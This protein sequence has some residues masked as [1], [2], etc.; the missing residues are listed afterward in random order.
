MILLPQIDTYKP[1]TVN[2]A[3]LNVNIFNTEKLPDYISKAKKAPHAEEVRI[4]VLYLL[5]Q[6]TGSSEYTNAIAT[7]I[8]EHL[9]EKSDIPVVAVTFDLRNHGSR[10][11]DAHKNN[12]WAKGN[13]SH[14]LDMVSSLHGNVADL[15]TI[16][17]FVPSYLDLEPLVANDD[18]P[19]KYVNAVSGYSLGAH[20]TI[21]FAAKH[22]ELVSV[23][24]TNVGCS[25]VTSL[26]VNRLR[27]T[28][29]F[30]KKWF[31]YEYNELQLSEQQ[32]KRLPEALFKLLAAED[33]YI[34]EN[35]PFSQINLFASFYSDDPLVPAK[36]STSWVDIYRNVNPNSD[37]YFEDGRVHNITPAMLE[38]FSSY[39]ANLLH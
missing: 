4:H 12:T 28:A 3:G 35:F 5:H 7:H 38:K 9:S 17:D 30:D 31:F 33:Q 6:R 16:M 2:I 23:I 22:P 37:V 34:F 29:E 8:L 15:K 1:Q 19:I 14:A 18:L 32:K 10:T 11:V 13:E 25:D 36:I 26:L 21:R 24:N 27:E 39:Y 20:T